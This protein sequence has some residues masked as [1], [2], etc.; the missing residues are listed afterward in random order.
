MKQRVRCARRDENQALQEDVSQLRGEVASY[1]DRIQQCQRLQAH[2][3]GVLADAVIVIRNTLKV[4]L[5][6]SQRLA[7]V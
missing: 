2:L 1:E 7:H 3:Q 4:R 5:S 6:S